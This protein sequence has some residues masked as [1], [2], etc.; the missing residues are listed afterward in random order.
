MKL[1][2]PETIKTKTDKELEI[3]SKDYSF[4][5]SEERLMAIKELEKRGSLPKEL[6][7]TKSILEGSIEEEKEE[8]EPKYKMTIKDLI[9]R[10][11]YLF[12]PLLIYINVFVFLIMV[13][14]GANFFTPDISSLINWGGNL[15]SLTLNGQYWR[16]LSSV[17]LHAGIFHLIFNMYALLYVGAALEASIG[18]I[19]FILAY[20][21]AGLFSSVS[22]ITINENIVSVG[23]SGAIFGLFGVLSALLIFKEFNVQ[24]ISRKSLLSSVGFFIFYNLIYGFG[25]AGIDNAAH[26]GGLLSGFVIGLAFVL[27]LKNRVNKGLVYISLVLLLLLVSTFTLSQVSNNYGKYNKV[28]KEFS[29]NEQKAMWM[30]REDLEAIPRDKLSFY[31]ER[32]NKEGIS[33]WDKNLSMLSD[34]QQLDLPPVLQD[35]IKLIIEYSELRKESCIIM[36]KAL[37]NPSDSLKSQLTNILRQ[38]EDKLTEIK[39]VNNNNR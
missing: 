27:I 30:Y 29:I 32:L 12:T 36:Q 18:K 21:L 5:S 39:N 23:A 3:I 16:L 25:K 22:S 8:K 17:F 20:I 6:I 9:P 15:R 4:Y 10:E 34:L 26:I 33:L 37:G 31:E 28:I 1:D 35:Q 2:F 19:K 24:N 38:I 11:N 14:S 7:G 13:I